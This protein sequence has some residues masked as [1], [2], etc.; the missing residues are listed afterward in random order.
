MSYPELFAL[1]GGQVPDLRGLF[2]RGHL[3]N[4]DRPL[5]VVPS[6]APPDAG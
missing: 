2:L 4:M 3:D 5:P 6:I 1:I